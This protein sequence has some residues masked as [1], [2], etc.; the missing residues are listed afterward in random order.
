MFFFWYKY[1][2]SIVYICLIILSITMLIF[3]QSAYL[4]NFK[5]LLIYLIS[6]SQEISTKIIKNTS[7]F[8][9][10]IVN[11]IKLK[12]ENISLHET[13]R[14]LKDENNR[15]KE[16][17]L[18]NKRLKELLGLRTNLPYSTITARVI[19]QSPNELYSTIIIDKGTSDGIAVNMPVITYH[20]DDQGVV[21]KISE[22]MNRV[23]KV[24]LLTNPLCRISALVMRSRIDGLVEGYDQSVQCQ[25]N[26]LNLDADIQLGDIIITSGKGSLFPKGLVIGKVKKVNIN[27]GKLY[28]AAQILPSIDLTKIEEVLVIRQ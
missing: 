5:V 4:T 16:E 2:V 13:I 22:T 19:A 21:G 28:K 15:L 18:E 17:S 27:K 1:K 7:N 14:K 10:N 11:L 9:T 20:N 25:I 26:Y 12:E 23:S 24:M 8:G 6:P 3:P